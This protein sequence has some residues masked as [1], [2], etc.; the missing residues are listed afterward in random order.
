MLEHGTL[1]P[2]HRRACPP[3]VGCDNTKTQLQRVCQRRDALGATRVL[4]NNDSFSPIRHVNAYPAGE[5]GFGDEVIDRALEE[6]LHL[7]G[8]EVDG[9]DMVHTGDVKKV[10]D[11]A[12]GDSPAVLLLLRL[13]R[14]WE[15]GHDSWRCQ[16]LAASLTV[17]K[18][19]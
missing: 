14:I 17:A 18:Y 10:C 15:V 5:E 9:H 1:V 11:H 13:A 8:V 16:Q 2:M 7:G 12:G 3:P 19:L 4:A 6:A